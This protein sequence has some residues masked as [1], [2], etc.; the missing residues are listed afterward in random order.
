MLYKYVSPRELKTFYKEANPSNIVLH[1]SLIVAFDEYEKDFLIYILS[2]PNS[3]GA[4]SFYTCKIPAPES[5]LKLDEDVADYS[6]FERNMWLYETTDY[7]GECIDSF[8]SREQKPNNLADAIY[9][10]L[11]FIDRRLYTD[12]EAFKSAICCAD[13]NR[14]NVEEV[15]ERQDEVNK[16]ESEAEYE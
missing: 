16:K 3:L 5:V 11:K 8:I 12:T 13:K 1:N 6:E 9:N 4:N 15:F 14:E 10:Y 2:R 7:I